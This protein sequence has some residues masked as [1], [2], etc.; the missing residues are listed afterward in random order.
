M[1]TVVR[2]TKYTVVRLTL[3]TVVGLTMYCVVHSRGANNVHSSA[4]A[5]RQPSPVAA[6]ASKANGQVAK[7]GDY[8]STSRIASGATGFETVTSGTLPATTVTGEVRPAYADG[9]TM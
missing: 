4:G 5:S 1:Y 6:T 8:G 3:Y 9:Q 2:L 7:M